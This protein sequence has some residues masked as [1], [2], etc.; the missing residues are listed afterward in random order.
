MVRALDVRR[1]AG[2]LAPS[3]DLSLWQTSWPLW[4]LARDA[5]RVPAWIPL[6][7]ATDRPLDAI[8]T[9]ERSGR[10]AR[11]NEL[12]RIERLGLDVRVT[13]EPDA[14]EDFRRRLYEPY[15]AQ[16][17]GALALPVPRHVLRHARRRGT[18]LLVERSGRAVAGAVL[19]RA[20]GDLRIL[21]F[22][23]DL[24]ADVPPTTGVEA[25]YYHAI[26]HA[27]A[28]GFRRLGL[29]TCRPVLS[30]GVLRYKRKW[31]AHLGR[32]NTWDAWLLRYRHTPA[33]RAAFTSAP[34]VVESRGNLAALVAAEESAIETQLERV[35]APGLTE[36]ACL[37]DD[38]RAVPPDLTSRHGTLRIVRG[39]E[40]WPHRAN[41]A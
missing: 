15:V 25:C 19:E 35:E 11:K 9:G 27:V 30:D 18:L 33:V 24:A 12:R 28:N 16:R 40:V 34:L 5:V 37:V 8:V 41:T 7:L 2:R 20:A 26:R 10:A 3:A 31:G 38:G 13:A 36:V 1:A 14:W 39:T 22:G 17:F 32:P 4:T 23:A 6:W 29:G 21:V